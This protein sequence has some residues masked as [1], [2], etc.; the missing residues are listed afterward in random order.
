MYS[1][2]CHGMYSFQWWQET[3]E[4]MMAEI[5]RCA[6]SFSTEQLITF[7]HTKFWE[8]VSCMIFFFLL[9]SPPS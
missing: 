9:A 6:C 2:V 7:I 5:W 3:T 4:L 1:C 8:N